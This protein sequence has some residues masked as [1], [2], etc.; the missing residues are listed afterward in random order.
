M[1]HILRIRTV[2]FCVISVHLENSFRIFSVYIKLILRT[3]FYGYK[4]TV[5]ICSNIYVI[6]CILRK[7]TVS[8]CVLYCQ[9]ITV[10]VTYFQ[11]I[12]IHICTYICMYMYTYVYMYMYICR[13]IYIYVYILY[14]PVYIFSCTSTFQGRNI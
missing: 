7:R 13:Y 5:Q 11:N 10:Y 9:Y 6:P 1:T 2:S 14:I 12:Y 4:N 8:F 3:V